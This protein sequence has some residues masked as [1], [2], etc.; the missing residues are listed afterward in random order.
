[1]MN[2]TKQLENILDLHK[3]LHITMAENK[4]IGMAATIAV[5]YGLSEDEFASILDHTINENELSTII[6]SHLNRTINEI[7]GLERTSIPNTPN[8][9]SAGKDETG[10]YIPKSDKSVDIDDDDENYKYDLNFPERQK[11]A[12][13]KRDA[14][15]ERLANFIS[16][17][18][19]AT[20]PKGNTS[21][22]IQKHKTQLIQNLNR[23]P[24]EKHKPAV[25]KVIKM[26][27]D[28]GTAMTQEQHKD[29]SKKQWAQNYGHRPIQRESYELKQ[30][31]LNNIT[32]N[33]IYKFSEPAV[34]MEASDSLANQNIGGQ[35][36]A[37]ITSMISAIKDANIDIH[38]QGLLLKR[39]ITDIVKGVNVNVRPDQ[40]TIKSEIEQYVKDAI[41][42]QAK[43]REISLAIKVE[44]MNPDTAKKVL[45]IYKQ[46]IDSTGK[47]YRVVKGRG[48][49]E[50][51]IDNEEA[52]K[53][54]NPDIEKTN[55]IV[56]GDSE[57]SKIL[58]QVKEKLIEIALHAEAGDDGKPSYDYNPIGVIKTDNSTF[59]AYA[60][61][62]AG[63]F[64]ILDQQNKWIKIPTDSMRR[65]ANNEVKKYRFT[66]I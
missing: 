2:Y 34:K 10:D 31:L 3:P 23:L 49:Y 55:N 28:A 63:V 54:T 29:A 52:S 25:Q 33:L 51:V 8:K 48:V 56:G 38:T 64:W 41:V 11:H 66:K 12:E 53:K 40:N 61:K 62:K 6:S 60:E 27:L 19:K 13:L 46:V 36:R 43:N 50:F 14:K 17:N 47:K 24:P 18:Q 16:N 26:M 65:L 37:D 7:N 1:M 9:P 4:L 32:T 45:E 42:K 15:K 35:V 21:Q 5:M 39:I 58:S 20:D 44:K 22:K 57:R 30:E 59:F